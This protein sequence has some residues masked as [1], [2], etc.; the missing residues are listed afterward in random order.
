MSAR[1]RARSRRS[2]CARSG[3]AT[4]AARCTPC[5]FGEIKSLSNESRD[6]SIVK[7][8]FRIP[9]DTDLGGVKK[10]IK[11]INAEIAA[12]PELGPNLIEPIKSQGI[13]RFE[14]Y[15]MVLRVK[16]TAKPNSYQ[17][18]IRREAYQRIRDAFEQ[19]G[20]KLGERSVKVEMAGGTA[21]AAGARRPA[22]G[23][24]RGL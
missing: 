24:S 12:D 7:L 11:A 14:E 17:F 23:V 8:E 4:S 6:W 21:A 9:F 16:Y 13:N 2:R 22:A 3:C 18:M 5:P 20:I 1:A 10:I 19:A 15:W